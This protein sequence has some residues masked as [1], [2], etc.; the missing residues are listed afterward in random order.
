[1]PNVLKEPRSSPPSVIKKERGLHEVAIEPF[2]NF[3]LWIEAVFN[4]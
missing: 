2:G 4:R 3:A 1:M